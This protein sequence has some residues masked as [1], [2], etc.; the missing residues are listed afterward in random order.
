MDRQAEAFRDASP[1]DW[2]TDALLTGAVVHEPDSPDPIASPE[3]WDDR[4]WDAGREPP[5]TL[6]EAQALLAAR[7]ADPDAPDDDT[8]AGAYDDLGDV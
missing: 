4:G 3:E 5:K 2:A 1:G 6:T 7:I 8:V